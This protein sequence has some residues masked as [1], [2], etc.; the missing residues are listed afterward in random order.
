MHGLEQ[1][2][3]EAARLHGVLMGDGAHLVGR[4]EALYQAFAGLDA[5]R[6]Q[7]GQGGKWIHGQAAF[8]LEV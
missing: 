4:D 7:R 8:Q 2:Q 6:Q 5:E 3:V 1:I